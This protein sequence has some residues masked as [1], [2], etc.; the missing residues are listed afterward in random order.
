VDSSKLIS[1]KP[2]HILVFLFSISWSHLYRRVV[3]C[4]NTPMLVRKRGLLDN[5][6][7]NHFVQLCANKN[8]K[9]ISTPCS[10][11]F[12]RGDYRSGRVIGTQSV[13]LVHWFQVAYV[14]FFKS[15]VGRILGSGYRIETVVG[16]LCVSLGCTSYRCLQQV[17]GCY[18][19]VI[20]IK[21]LRRED[22]DNNLIIWYQSLR[23]HGRN[24]YP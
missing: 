1:W 6:N 3:P 9:E 14:G 20:K 2:F 17:I 7:T 8:Q 16:S 13:L 24:L 11:V 18:Q 19:L 5:L 15:V 23:C 21:I 12:L 4:I 10:C 22:R